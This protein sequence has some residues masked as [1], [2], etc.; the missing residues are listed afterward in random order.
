MSFFLKKGLR[1][2]NIRNITP[3]ASKDI[4]IMS[5]KKYRI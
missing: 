5:I 3:E 4:F 2:A 1:I